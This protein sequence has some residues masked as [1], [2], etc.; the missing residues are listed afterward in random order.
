MIDVYSGLIVG[1][2]ISYL[3]PVSRYSGRRRLYPA[4]HRLAVRYAAGGL[5]CLAVGTVLPSWGYILFWPALALLIV[6]GGYMGLRERIWQKDAQGRISLSAWLILLPVIAG[7]HL[8][9]R[10][11]CRRLSPVSEIEDGIAIGSYPQQAVAQG[12]IL[13][14]TAEF[15]ASP[16]VEG[17]P[18]A[19]YPLLD[20]VVPQPQQLREAVNQLQHLHHQHRS[21]LVHCALGLSRS[22]L[23][24]AGW[25]IAQRNVSSV[26]Q[27]VEILREK[28]PEIV[29]T[30]EH[31]ALLEHVYEEEVCA[32]RK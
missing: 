9:R 18:Y 14:L 11:F 7:A 6:A 22:A 8:S 15:N 23:V 21:V 3:L 17:R 1:V 32:K 16:E 24:V 30:R 12:A 2:L 31:I 26:V 29:L 19:C 28:R 10:Y 27:A 5:L 20:L 4:H 25:L 13:D